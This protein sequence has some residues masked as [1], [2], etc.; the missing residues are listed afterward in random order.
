MTELQRVE[1]IVN[2]TVGKAIAFGIYVAVLGL[3]ELVQTIRRR[4]S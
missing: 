2:M 3:R 1:R 4:W